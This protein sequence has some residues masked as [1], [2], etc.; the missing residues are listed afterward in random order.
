MKFLYNTIVG[1]ILLKI[2]LHSKV[3]FILSEL[4]HSSFSSVF[5]RPYIKKHEIDMDDYKG[6]SYDSFA[7]FFARK[8]RHF[9]IDE[10]NDVLIS[11]C[12]G[13]LSIWS[14]DNSQKL[15][16]KNSWYSVNDLID[17]KLFND[18]FKD[19]ICFI[20][21]LQA[22]DNHH[23]CYIDDCYHD[24][25]HFIPGTLHSVQPAAC[26]KFP[27][28][29]LNRRKWSALYTK[30]FRIVAQIEVG[31][32]LVGDII[33]EK[34]NT[35]AV[36][37]E[38]MGHFELIGSTVVLLFSNE[39]RKFLCPLNDICDT[40]TEIPVKMGKPIAIKKTNDLL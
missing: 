40:G 12:D 5:I 30:N 31:A 28:Y 35:T 14:V 38:E 25:S 4:M 16:I 39:A 36:R 26:D 18:Y 11:P 23:F 22:S 27:V 32:V 8:R 2:L 3:L 17:D 21:R 15:H 9:I 34:E 19:G 20:I 6:Q 13:L 24:H 37:G 33:H 1:R 7:D 29:Q 10:R